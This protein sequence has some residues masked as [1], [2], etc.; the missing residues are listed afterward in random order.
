MG[1]ME[2]WSGRED[3][4]A[5]GGFECAG[6]AQASSNGSLHPP[7]ANFD[8]NSDLFESRS[9][10]IRIRELFVALAVQ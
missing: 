6:G 2:G 8:G 3:S 9:A 4:S 10:L 5:S 1:W 7:L